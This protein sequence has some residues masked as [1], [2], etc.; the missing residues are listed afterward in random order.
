[1]ARKV[2]A[3]EASLGAVLREVE[4]KLELLGAQTDCPIC[5]EPIIDCEGGEGEDSGLALGCAHSLHREC[6]RH[7]SAHCV[8]RNKA[9]FCP[10]C[11]NDDF[12]DEIF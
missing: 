2:T 8:S 3:N 6:W 12:L 4:T 7:W 1:M 9:A 5:L 11:R 10:L